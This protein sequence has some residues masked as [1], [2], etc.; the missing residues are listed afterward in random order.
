MAA[1]DA[2]LKLKVSLDLAFFRQQLAGLGAAT[3]GTPMTVQIKF[4]RRG[5]Q[6][7]LNALG[8]NI[9]KRDYRLTIQTN[10]KTEIEQAKKL[11][12]AYADLEKGAFASPQPKQRG[13]FTKSAFRGMDLGDVKKLYREAANAGLLAYDEAVYKN[14]RKV[15]EALYGLGKD[16]IAGLLNGLKSD[17]DKLQAAA[18]ALGRDLIASVKAVLGIASPSKEFKK[19]GEDSGEGFEQGLKSGLEE[20]TRMSVQ[21]MRDLFR[22][23]QGEAKSGAARLQ[24]TM[25]A[26]MA[27]LV[28]LPGGRQQRRR[29][30]QSAEGINAAMTGAAAINIGARQAGVRQQ[31]AGAASAT[32]AFMTAL[33]MMF[34]M[35]ERELM[36]RLQGLYGQQYRAPS[37]GGGG[38]IPSQI[39]T[40]ISSITGTRGPLGTGGGA[41]GQLFKGGAVNPGLLP[42]GYIG[43]S[44]IS[45]KFVNYPAGMPP[46][47][48]SGFIEPTAYGSLAAG[49]TGRYGMSGSAAFPLSPMMRGGIGAGAGSF[50]PM[51]T[52]RSV[53]NFA[54][55]LSALTGRV[56]D[57]ATAVKRQLFPTF[58]DLRTELIDINRSVSVAANAQGN[59]F[60]GNYMKKSGQIGMYDFPMSGMMGPSTPLGTMGQFP[61]AGMVYPS[62]PLGRITAQSSMFGGGG[63]QPP[64]GGGGG[65][66]RFGGMVPGAGNF[67]RAIGG[68]GNL[69]GAGTIREL[70]SEFGFATKQVLLFGQAYK[71]LAFI[72]D[73]P[74]QVANAVAQLQSFRNT[75][76]SVTGS[77][78]A[79]ADANEFILAAVEKYSIPLQSARDGF[80]KLFAS[81]EP[82]GFAAGEIQNLFLG[83][84]KAAATYGLSADK[85]DRVNYAFAQMASKG[86][87]MSEELKGQLGDVLP[88]AM[89]I[90][91]EAA[92]FKGPDAIQK[93][94]KAL[95]DGVY[96]GG[97]MRE[98]L[99]N[100][101]DEMNKEFGPGAEGAAK[102]FQGAMNRMQT[103]TAKLYESFEPAAIGVLNTVAVPLVNTLKNLTD[104]VNAYFSGQQAAT[105]AAQGFAD[106]LK[107]LVPTLA[108]IGEN[109][110]YVFQQVSILVQGF[111]AVALQ[112]ARLLALPIV[113]YLAGA[114]VQ[115]LLLTTAFQALAA[116]GLGAALVAIGR[117]IAQGIVY[118]QVTLGMRVATQQTT[119]AMYQF[120]TAVQTVMIKSVVGI[121]LVA[122]GALISRLVELQ[123]AM[124]SVSGQSKAMGDAAKASA[125]L[126]DVAG[127]K[128]A[129]GNMEDRVQTYQRIKGELD[130]TIKKD[131]AGSSFYREIPT[132]LAKD[133]MSLG[134]IVENSMRKTGAGYKV[135]IGD[136]RDAYGL[137][138]K[139]VSEFNDEIN[140][141]Q[142][143]VGKAEQQQKKLKEQG[144]AG[145]DMAAGDSKGAAKALEDARK[146]ADDK[147]KYE[148]EMAKK[149][150][151]QA[152]DLD[153]MA[154]EHW[155]KLQE[156]KY[157]ILIAGENSWLSQAIKFQKELQDV[158]IS[159]I[160]TVRKAREATAKA[161]IEAGTKSYVAG[162]GGG[163]AMFGA[164][165]RTFNAP[166]WVHGHFQ[167]MN[168]EAL[169]SDTVDVVMKLLSQGVSPELGSGAKFSAGMSQDQVT[170]LVRQG[171][172]SHKSYASGAGAVDVFVPQGTRVPVPLSGVGNLGGAA[173][174]TGMLPGGTQLMH[175]APGSQSGGGAA[176]G[177]P[178]SR[179]RAELKKDY[180]AAL[181]A[182]EALNKKEQENLVIQYNNAEVRARIATIIKQQVAEI[183]PV[184]EQKLE[185]SL[186]KEKISLV[187][188][189]AF[190]AALDT[191]E[192]IAQAT[193]K[194]TLNIGLAKSK[195]EENNN[196]AKEQGWTNEQLTAENKKQLDYITQQEKALADYVPL[197][198]ERLA[199]E[200]ATA[201]AELQRQIRQATPL[202]GMGLAAGFIGPAADKYMEAKGLGATDEEASRLAELQNQLTILETRN[203]AVKQS[204][205]GIGNAFGET[206]TTG[207]ASLIAGT[208]TAKEVFA[209]FLQSVAQALSQAAAQMIATYI[210]IGVARMFAGFQSSTTG[211]KGPNPG[212]IP[213][214]GN[215]TAPTTNIG[216][217]GASAN[218]AANGALWQGGFTAFANGG[219][220]AGPTLGLI[221]EGGEP[222]FIIPS[223]KMEGAMKRYNNGARGAG[224]I[225]SGRDSASP[226]EP[227]GMITAGPIDVRYTVE[228]INSVDYVTADQFQAGMSRAAQQGALQ[229]EQ[230][231]L[232]KLRNSQTVRSRMGI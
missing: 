15:E 153:E 11:A 173:G 232:R 104:G 230:R 25:L 66:G 82:A 161:E 165:G 52:G 221:G 51:E 89:G 142:S 226:M 155:K 171:I 158:E 34:G 45:P 227:G 156:E 166:G 46:V 177:V 193:E 196:L 57:A 111:G 152:L 71:L 58:G 78:D 148:A 149:S 68:L 129:I 43:R 181:A 122:I 154:F 184:E 119:V 110:K 174:M 147:A 211:A 182:Q 35:S 99:R 24:A 76:L 140:K 136:L 18:K 59:R 42:S 109:L 55:S 172:A 3:A 31:A 146:L 16:S 6:N 130:K 40:L 72:Q 159:R 123:N 205:Y 190:G 113:R 133:L 212:G 178:A 183:T 26:A 118:A 32:P 208:A 112:V 107:T 61:S 30:A 64:G 80:T 121:A 210:A 189:G 38:A 164:T 103:A 62:S 73:F 215:V 17:N 163:A 75:L 198:R 187:S 160:E 229:G 217:L 88:G 37:I 179:Q 63:M 170:S 185:N 176:G 231:T 105:P 10:L 90:F 228:R 143:L 201:A 101:A 218:L 23:L 70:G 220:V 224:V 50:V 145:L 12:Q 27:G 4:D 53:N 54:E 168:R 117:F 125:K 13:S 19:I 219:M 175:L 213:S 214:T 195:I 96:K 79:A 1:Q 60:Y 134:L 120:G 77:A 128:E 180:N 87:V 69:P 84:S 39:G 124:A 194:A 97:K 126:G 144:A 108:G 138:A 29:L 157:N 206:M 41:I 2:E 222:E 197:L 137:A 162:A 20:A 199:L 100:V 48:G 33:P 28:Q 188:S 132:A 139:N 21:E 186:I 44:A 106:V 192:K 216:D 56:K 151:L 65:G 131:A 204:I 83:I 169:V 81:M 67:G 150:N 9:R 223:S 49:T 36:S 8:A 115:T 114:Y 102:T 5:V 167:N 202:G 191:E 200:Q 203:E 141:S 98:L 116:S 92:G 91:A 207:V 47:Y 94:G 7:E 22:A 95:E 209:S 86:Q 127:V 74:G 135:K 225:P 93:F 85:V 14:R